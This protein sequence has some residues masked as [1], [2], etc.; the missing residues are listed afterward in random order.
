MAHIGLCTL[1]ATREL[2]SAVLKGD[3]EFDREK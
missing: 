1:I 3:L 2:D